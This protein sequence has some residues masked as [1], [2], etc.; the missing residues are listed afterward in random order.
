MSFQDRSPFSWAQTGLLV[1]G[2][3]LLLVWAV[4]RY[5][6][7]V[8]HFDQWGWTDLY[9]KQ[10]EGEL[11]WQ[12]LW[13]LNSSNHRQLVPNLQRLI[14][15]DLTD[16]NVKLELYVNLG[17]ALA[18]FAAFGALLVQTARRFNA[19]PLRLSLVLVAAFYFSI[20]QFENWLGAWQST[21]FYC[22]GGVLAC[23]AFLTLRRGWPWPFI[24][25]A[26]MAAV[27]SYS[28]A[29]GLL[30]WVCGLFVIVLDPAWRGERRR[31]L[32]AALWVGLGLCAWWVYFHNYVLTPGVA[33]PS[34]YLLEHPLQSLHFCVIYF[35]A[36]LVHVFSSGS[37]WAPYASLAGLAAMAALALWFFRRQGR[38]GFLAMTP[39]WALGL[40]GLGSGAMTAV[41]RASFGL[42]IARLPR[43]ISMANFAWYPLL[44]LAAIAAAH[45]LTRSRQSARLRKWAA[46]CL[47]IAIV[48]IILARMARPFPYYA[49]WHERTERGK[50]ALEAFEDEEALLMIYHNVEYL[51]Q[52]RDLLREYKAGP[53]RPGLRQEDPARD[54]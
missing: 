44:V 10:Q 47:R 53:Y 54:R 49:W 3:F 14:L 48:L 24:A 23:V 28:F 12:D 30:A 50:A 17:I 18:A 21:I 51:K 7:D 29:T 45:W 22:N 25:A 4:H 37:P 26:C 42:A 27:A 9:V 32:Y 35:S 16:W 19:F 33:S 15:S 34:R 43:Y 5:G 41:S 39:V 40:Y 31:P 13:A 52:Y 20:N 2:L 6:V 11:T 46:P 38:E 8:P 1:G 36:P